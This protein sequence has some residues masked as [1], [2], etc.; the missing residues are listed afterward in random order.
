[1]D[2]KLRALLDDIEQA[3]GGMSPETM[4]R[5]PE[6]KWS[7]RDVLEHLSRAYGSTARALQRTVPEGKP[8]RRPTLKECV[9][10]VYVTKLGLFPEGREAPEFTVPRGLPASEVVSQIRQN[11]IDMDREIELAEQKLGRKR[12]AVHPIVGP[13]T[14]KGWRK[15][16]DVHTRHHLKQ[17]AAL[18]Q[19]IS[20]AGRTVAQGS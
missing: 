19:W 13:L 8:V 4:E 15:F 17:I 16:H 6:G 10:I 18:K 5:A 7:V 11:L 12:I 2:V 20:E 3:I 14:A 9:A 1:M